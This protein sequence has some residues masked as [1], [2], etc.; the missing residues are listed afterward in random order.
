[1]SERDRAG[2][3]NA[4]ASVLRR[5]W[6]TGLI[7]GIPLFGVAAA[8]ILLATPIYRAE[9]RLRLGEP[10]P[11]TG[12]SPTAGFFGLMRL[13]GDPFA[14]DLELLT[15]RT[16]TEQVVRDG[17]LNAMLIAPRGWHRDSVFSSFVADSTTRAATYAMEWTRAGDVEVRMTAP[18]DSMIGVASPG[19]AF[20][21]GGITVTPLPL[22]VGMP[23]RVRVK[24]VPFGLAVMQ[25]APRI[26]AVRSRREANVVD[27]AFDQPDP[28]LATDV[29]GSVIDRFIA[30]R[31]EIQRR[32]SGQTVDSLRAV[33]GQT[34]VELAAAESALEAWQR[35]TRL[36]APDIQS[37]VFVTRY[38]DLLTLV[39]TA[40]LDLDAVI[41]IA[42]RMEAGKDS[43]A[44][45]SALLSYPQFVE[46]EAIGQLVARQSALEQQR[47][48]LATRRAET[49]REYSVLVEQIEQ[50]EQTIQSLIQSLRESLGERL[51]ALRAEAAEMDAALASMPAQAIELGRRSR[52]IRLLSEI[53]LLTEQ[54]LRQE[55]LR[56]A[57]TFSNVQVIDPP[58]IRFKPVWPR[59]TMGLGIG[60]ILAGALAV[61][62]MIVAERADRRVRHAAEI[63]SLVG[64]PVVIATVADGRT[65]RALTDDEVG[66]VARRAA[67]NGHP[68]RLGVAPVD[69]GERAA[70]IARALSNGESVSNG[71]LLTALPAV[72][73]LATAAKAAQNPITLV[74][75][76]G[77]TRRDALLRSVRLLEAVGASVVGT[78]VV[79]ERKHDL[80]VLWS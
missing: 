8:L 44:A 29:V 28:A 15:S 64:V 22:R 30:L 56:Q 24:T 73:N 1:M 67:V 13:G 71:T 47:A 59:R 49:S 43:A 42:Q 16:L 63:E 7:V 17:S 6:R 34:M 9:A 51:A 61:L 75:H 74:V 11:M 25:T 55:E 2:S 35:E 60:F 21:F 70:R 54:R 65:V 23:E 14:N 20:G 46:S 76:I 62:A 78:I 48:E 58:R 41:G 12:V 37:E 39:E 52:A 10:P 19:A 31:T 38:G 36:V 4:W 5:R 69:G 40:Q 3:L 33:A 26:R 27:L 57:L 50:T 32:E 79:C 77:R 66:A 18:H 72:D 68:A 53:V 45:W 80:D